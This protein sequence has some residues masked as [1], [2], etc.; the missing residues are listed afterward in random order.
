MQ[1]LL[2]KHMIG[3]FAIEIAALTVAPVSYT[4]LDVYK[5]QANSSADAQVV[6]IPLANVQQTLTIFVIVVS[7]GSIAVMVGAGVA[8]SYIISGT[9]KPLERVSAVA[10]DVAHLDLE[11]HTISSAVRV[12]PLSL[13]HISSGP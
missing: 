13:I 12:E 2:S 5:R 8:G 3:T 1:E 6:G 10:T 4:H 9:M 7:L 11:E